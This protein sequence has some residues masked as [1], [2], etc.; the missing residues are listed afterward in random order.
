MDLWTVL[1]PSGFVSVFYQDSQAMT[2]VTN[3]G[4]SPTMK[5]LHS[6]HRVS[7]ASL[8][9]WLGPAPGRDP[10]ML[11]HAEPEDMRASPYARRF[12]NQD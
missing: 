6:A 2:Q 12:A 9:E 10:A 7:V 11:E 3:T 4:R 5:Y 8:H 1:L